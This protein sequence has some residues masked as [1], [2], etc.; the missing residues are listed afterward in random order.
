ME[1]WKAARPPAAPVS[2]PKAG[3]VLL[4]LLLCWAVVR[5]ATAAPGTRGAGGPVENAVVSIFVSTMLSNGRGT[6]FCVGDGSWV[7]TCYH[8]V[9]Q[10]VGDDKDLPINR[11]LILSP[12]SG[13]ALKAR[14]V[15]TD[16]KADLA[17]LTLE[18]GR[19]PALPVAGAEGCQAAK[20]T[21]TGE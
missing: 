7:V 20:L 8:V 15:A 18:H 3:A 6:G 2:R 21:A 10:R 17:L 4:A 12:W 19:L 1:S 5:P 16:P 9:N 14:V 13:E 11:A